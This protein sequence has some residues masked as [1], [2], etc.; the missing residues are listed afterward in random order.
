MTA[1][2]THEPQPDLAPRH[3][4]SR[5]PR[6]LFRRPGGAGP[7]PLDAEAGVLWWSH[8][9]DTAD[10]GSSDADGTG[11][12]AELWWAEGWGLAADYYKS[13]PDRRG[14]GDTTD[15]SVDVKRRVLSPTENNFIALGVGWQ[16]AEL[17]GGHTTEGVRL[18][19]DARVGLGILHAYGRAVWMPDL[20]DAGPRDDISGHEY[21]GRRVVH[22][23]S[24]P[25]PARRLPDPGTRLRRRLR[26][27]RRL[28]PCRRHP[29]LTP[30]AHAATR[31]RR[32]PPPRPCPRRRS[33]PRRCETRAPCRAHVP[34]WS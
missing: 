6:R 4:P 13:D 15:F 28:S 20:G 26:G 24:I 7:G 21:Q 1:G 14:F 2:E 22:A 19:A 10:L 27:S 3:R 29:L 25:Q 33:C 5:R 32:A 11:A 9:V 31:R 23:V 17:V 18:T 8:D 30:A 34:R 16:D 12:Y